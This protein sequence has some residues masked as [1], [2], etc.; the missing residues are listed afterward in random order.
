MY[1]LDRLSIAKQNIYTKINHYNQAKN[2]ITRV[3]S[4]DY[5]RPGVFTYPLIPTLIYSHEPSKYQDANS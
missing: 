4:G 3:R 5:A 1:L 2:G